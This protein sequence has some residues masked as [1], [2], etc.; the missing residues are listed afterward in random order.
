MMHVA[1]LTAHTYIG[2]GRHM[3]LYPPVLVPV[4]TPHVSM[5]TL[6][7]LNIN[8]K[9]SKTVIGPFGFQFIGQGNDSGFVV[10]HI[11]IPPPSVLVPVVIAFG[12]SKPMFSASTV[13]IDV[14]G[15]GLAMA[16]GVIPYNFI[17][18]NQACNDPLNYPSDMVICPNTVV[19]GLTVG[20]FIGGLI[21]VVVDCVISGIANK[22]G[23]GVAEAIM[24]KIGGRIAAAFL[25]EF[26]ESLTK[27]FGR[28]AAERMARE[29]GENIME[30]PFYR[31]VREALG[32]ITENLFGAGVDTGLGWAGAPSSG[33]LGSTAG[34]AIDAPGSD[35]ATSNANSQNYPGAAPIHSAE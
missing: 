34:R 23:G 17:S 8:A 16:A 26:T 15:V 35:A 9:W 1:H 20:D 29:A 12:G 6:L 4:L 10:P 33:D 31:A 13:Q 21:N 5:D 24:N 18:F 14:D 19:V 3:A 28:E 22:V 7:G 11:A 25:G 30:R 2:L 32:K 27:I